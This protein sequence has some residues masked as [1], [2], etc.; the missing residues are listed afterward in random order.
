MFNSTL[1][2]KT[3]LS[4]LITAILF[5]SLLFACKKEE[6]P[7]VVPPQTQPPTSTTTV[8][9]TT[10]PLFDTKG[11]SN[12]SDVTVNSAKITGRIEGNG[13]LSISQY[14]HV[15]SKTNQ[16]PTSA[17][18]KTELG[19][20]SG[21]F[22]LTFISELKSLEPNTSYTVRAYATNSV[23]TNYGP[24][25]TVTTLTTPVVS[26]GKGVVFVSDQYGVTALDASTGKANWKAQ[27][28]EFV[29][30]YSYYGFSGFS[31]G[32]SN[33]LLYTTA[34]N[35]PD[36]GA[37]GKTILFA[38]NT[39][40]GTKKWA[41]EALPGIS[42]SAPV[43]SGGVVYF[44][45]DTYGNAAPNKFSIVYAFDASTGT[46]KWEY[47]STLRIF[48]NPTLANGLLYVG[49]GSELIGLDISSGLPKMKGSG[50]ITTNPV[51]M[52]NVVY[53]VIKNGTVRAFD[54]TTGAAI[55]TTAKAIGGQA[56]PTITNTILYVATI[57][58]TTA[59]DVKTG[60]EKWSSASG[61][62]AFGMSTGN[63][64][65]YVCS[66]DRSVHA[67][68]AST[69]SQKWAKA[70]TENVAG[71][72]QVGT[73][74]YVS[75]LASL[76]ALN[77]QTGEQLWRYDD[78]SNPGPPIFLDATGKVFHAPLSGMQQ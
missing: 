23:G 30:G 56:P 8:T 59:L 71:N 38:L 78:V 22:P 7:N 14:G 13:N 47:R 76:Y 21:P 34:S 48:N 26:A 74:L 6:T 37:E 54:A 70:F 15:W 1:S 24:V 27:M 75:G 3:N 17:D 5:F 66:N 51:V 60:Q 32:V 52:D 31:A 39:A 67:L 18:S 41:S 72:L 49:V 45:T 12:V 69:G 64:L 33:N 16:M 63:E 19:T 58:A 10:I 2:V 65:V 40:D 57:G 43:I 4:Y 20:T 61:V 9:T 73:V 36:N 53:S 68:E 50:E 46:K 25:N 29:S 77:A 42:F 62:R 28:S 44:T 55:W 11:I 35:V